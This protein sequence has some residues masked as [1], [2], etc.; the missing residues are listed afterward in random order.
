MY[1]RASLLFTGGEGL[2]R[3]RLSACPQHREGWCPMSRFA[4]TVN[5]RTRAIFVSTS[6]MKHAQKQLPIK[7][8]RVTETRVFKKEFKLGAA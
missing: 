4:Q 8:T 1:F 5:G 6:E 2:L 7:R 3:N